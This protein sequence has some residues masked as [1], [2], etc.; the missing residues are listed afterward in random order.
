MAEEKGW[1]SAVQA[2]LSLMWRPN[3]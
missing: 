2:G 3:P 1:I